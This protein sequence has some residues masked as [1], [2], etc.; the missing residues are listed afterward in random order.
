M[1]STEIIEEVVTESTE[2]IEV[3]E[4]VQTSID[5]SGYY[6]LILEYLDSING[7]LYR[8]NVSFEFFI[9]VMI[10]VVICVVYYNYLKYF[11]RF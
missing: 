2:I 6:D 3:I 8:L 5:Y 1:E 10:T 4:T 7:F 11:T 9:A